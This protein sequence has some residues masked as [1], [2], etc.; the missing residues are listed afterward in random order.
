MFMA[1][2]LVES[3]AVVLGY[4]LDF[5]W[6]VLIIRALLSWVNPDPYNPIVMFLQRVTDPILAPIQRRMRS[7]WMGIDLAPM[8]ALLVI[9][10]LRTFLIRSLFDFAG[11]LR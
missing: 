4:A 9:L 3:I 6:W 2:N 5:Y 1:A 10:F 7:D 8:V 11:Q